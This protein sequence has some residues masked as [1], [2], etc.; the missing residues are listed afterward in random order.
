[1]SWRLLLAALSLAGLF[2]V[3]KLVLFLADRS[4]EPTSLD[5][6]SSMQDEPQGH[7]SSSAPRQ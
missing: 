4:S 2:L 6:R 1:M 3:F 5:I 7:S